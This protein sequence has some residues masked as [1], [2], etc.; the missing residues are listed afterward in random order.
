MARPCPH[1]DEE[2]LPDQAQFC[3]RCGHRL[4]GEDDDES[5]R[6]VPETTRLDDP[7]TVQLDLDDERD[8]DLQTVQ[9]DLDEETG[10][11]QTTRDLSESTSPADED[12][13]T[14]SISDTDIE[15]DDESTRALLE[16]K[17]SSQPTVIQTRSEDESTRYVTPPLDEDEMTRPLAE[18]GSPPPDETPPHPPDV[19]L[20]T[21]EE[22]LKSGQI[23][24]QRYRLEKTL[25]RGGF[26][27]VYLA[28]DMKLRRRCVVK[29]MLVQG[30]S[31]KEIALYRANFRREANLLAELNDPGHPNIPEIYDYFSTESGNYLV[32]KYIEGRNLKDSLEQTQGAIPWREA[33]RYAIDVCSAL[34]YMHSKGS[35][36]I[37]HRDIKPANILLGDD[38]RVWLVDFG[39]A[40]AEP[41]DSSSQEQG[42]TKASGSLG[43]TPLEQWLGQATPASD[44]YALGATLH[45]MVTGLNPLDAYNGKFNLK[46]IN[47]L[48]GQFPPI[49][50]IDRKLPR[51]LDAI[52]QRAI[53]ATAD[54]RPT[55]RQLQQQLEALITAGQATA[56]YTFKDGSS[57]TTIAELVEL[58]EANRQEAQEYLYSGDFERWFLLINRNDLVQAAVQAVAQGKN[59]A[60]GLERFLKLIMPNLFWRRAGKVTRRVALLLAQIAL[61]TLAI[62]LL[63]AVAGSYGLR[64]FAQQSIGNMDWNFYAL[65]VGQDNAYTEAYLAEQFNTFYLF[66]RNEVKL[67]PP[68]RID[69]IGHWDDLPLADTVSVPISATITLENKQPRF[70]VTAING[71][72]LFLVGENISGGINEGIRAAFQKSPVDITRLQVKPREVVFHVEETNDPNRPPY[73]PP[74]VSVTPTPLPSPT[75]TGTAMLIVFNQASYDI[76]LDIEGETSWEIAGET[77]K[78]I[79]L[80][81]GTYSYAVRAKG[82]P[83]SLAAGE[84]IWNAHKAYRLDI[85]P[86][87][88]L[89]NQTKS[90][91]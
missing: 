41:V 19:T 24:E 27:A 40:K 84:K 56:L 78:V 90:E 53:A 65:E 12:E 34:D 23:L 82:E 43:Y 31:P 39:L 89:I 28:E 83:H 14:R 81:A 52:V 67:S 32:M 55:P 21:G 22:T 74:V 45:H 57:A 51:Q 86:A 1:C 61:I 72:P 54:E 46:I 2:N 16:N 35:E 4:P 10:E 77:T 60:H 91:K 76:I 79:E 30:Q 87:D 18:S 15:D 44:I 75:P 9:L 85:V 73:N 48:H 68:N 71:L 70:Q 50:K 5:T 59:R 8:D 62:V 64:R 47:D 66:N 37:L 33:V 7:Q 36:P 42:A 69:L 63:L 80:P 17:G 25:G 58:C 13:S 29:Q 11:D 20:H 49:R 26:G 3:Y 88:A 6:F 38:G